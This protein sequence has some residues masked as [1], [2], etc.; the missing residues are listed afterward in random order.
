ML[1]QR[2]SLNQNRQKGI[3]L[4]MSLVML[5]MLTIM[6]ISSV[7]TTSLQLRM[8]RN[9]TDSNLAFQASESALRDAEDFIETL[10]DMN[11]FEAANANANGFYTEAGPGETPNWRTLNW[12]GANGFREAETDLT[13]VAVR[14]RYIVEHVKTVISDADALNL[15]NIGQD[16]GSGRTQI[17]R[18]TTR[19]TGGTDTAQVMIQGTYG[20]RL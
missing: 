13:G 11:D 18:V 6:G 12:N 16:T 5:L 9:A 19:G 14:P 20:K 10:N 2:V 1:N 17:F 4:F 3:A 8:A 7:Q 15:D